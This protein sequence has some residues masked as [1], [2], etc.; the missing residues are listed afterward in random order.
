M[1]NRTCFI[2][3]TGN[4]LTNRENDMDKIIIGKSNDDLTISIFLE[5]LNSIE[6]IDSTNRICLVNNL[7]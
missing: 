3:K 7:K 2:C 1:T 6:I 5:Q 4:D